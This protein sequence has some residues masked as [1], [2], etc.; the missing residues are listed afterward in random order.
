M[1]IDRIFNDWEEEEFDNTN[2]DDYIFKLKKKYNMVHINIGDTISNHGTK[3]K[4]IY[5]PINGGNGIHPKYV[6]N[7]EEYWELIKK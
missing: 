5:F 4:R 6:E 1:D 3:E 2:Y 7:N